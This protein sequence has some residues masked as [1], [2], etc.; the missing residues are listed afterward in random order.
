ML[1]WLVQTISSLDEWRFALMEL[2]ALYVMISGTTVMPRLSA[3][4]LATHSMV[5]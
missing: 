5:K 4:N 1:E 3:N 2:G